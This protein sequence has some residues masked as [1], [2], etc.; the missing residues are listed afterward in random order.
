MAGLH[1]PSAAV[2]PSPPDFSICH[3]FY[4]THLVTSECEAAARLLPAG[5]SPITSPSRFI[6]SEKNGNCKI[7]I[8][9]LNP[10]NDHTD[11]SAAPIVT[12]DDFRRM[13]NWLIT[14]CVSTNA[15][16]GFGTIGLRNAIDWIA[17]E[18]TTEATIRNGPLP[19]SASYFTVT[20]G[21]ADRGSWMD[22]GYDDP[23]IARALSDGVREKGNS[24]RADKLDL[25]SQTMLRS[26]D[27]GSTVSWWTAFSGLDSE[28]DEPS[29]EMVYACDAQLGTPNA[30]DCSQLA[31][32][33]LGSPSDTVSIGPGS[34]TRFLSF[35]SCHA[36]VT[37][38]ATIALTW[39]QI[40]AGL[41]TLVDSCV[42][43]PLVGARGGRA[44]Y[45]KSTGSKRRKRAV[46]I[47]GLDALP[48][49]VNITL[50]D[51]AKCPKGF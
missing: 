13:A 39:A 11:T 43:H 46:V 27:Q 33:G 28:D 7:E 42:M 14:T 29:S 41:N 23:A 45:A 8:A 37:S 22:P 38:L 15:I 18:A 35:G 32:S 34:A 26:N 40:S 24:E 48:P 20:V 17:N 25:L 36:A 49:G 9:W 19:R 50:C 2:P 21:R 12:P 51:A 5:A 31:Y 47:N 10:D 44:F 30:V 3:P 4:G 16:G 1:P 6:G